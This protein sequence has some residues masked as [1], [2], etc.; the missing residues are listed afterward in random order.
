VCSVYVHVHM[1]VCVC[2]FAC[3]MMSVVIQVHVRPICTIIVHIGTIIIYRSIIIY[4]T[5]RSHH[6]HTHT[7]THT[8][9]QIHLVI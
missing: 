5:M 6:T 3:V 1:R 8:R 2:E 7:H 9:N 4:G